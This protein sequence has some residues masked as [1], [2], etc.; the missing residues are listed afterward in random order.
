[1]NILIADDHPLTRKGIISLLT[2]SPDHFNCYEA[3]D[4]AETLTIL[5]AKK[6][7]VVLLGIGSQFLDGFYLL[8]YIQ[9]NKIR[10]FKIIVIT[11]YTD[12]ILVQWLLDNG[13]DG[14]VSKSSAPDDTLN[15]ISAVSRGY[16]YYPQELS[17]DLKFPTPPYPS[18]KLSDN[19]QKILTL[20]ANGDTS[21][22]IAA[23]L[24][25]TLRTIETK[26]RRLEKKLLVK[27]S[28][29]LI[30]VAYRT[31][32]LKIS[33]NGT[34]AHIALEKRNM[35]KPMR[36]DHH[37]GFAVEKSISSL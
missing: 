36:T 35:R 15:A 10:K 20:I 18:L 16:H 32:L 24:G 33:D 12:P 30:S 14:Y 28:S 9:S 6:P 21:K 29:E 23:K 27:N 17:Q 4:I 37:G 3:S 19:D 1:M 8:R 26:R 31:G 5:A 22:E 11:L 25:Y 13:V 2:E 34:S 7:D